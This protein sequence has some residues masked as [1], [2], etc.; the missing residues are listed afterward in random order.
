MSLP[1]PALALASLLALGLVGCG[2][3]GPSRAPAKAPAAAAAPAPEKPR[4]AIA[5]GHLWRDEVDR[6]L[7]TLGLPWL[8]RRV[9]RESAFAKDGRFAGWLITG[10]P[11][12]WSTIDLKP[13]DVVLRVNGKSLETPEDAWDAWKSV[14]GVKEIKLTLERNGAPKELS[15][16]IDGDVNPEIAR[17]M[18]QGPPAGRGQARKPEPERK[19]TVRIGGDPPPSGGGSDWQGE[20]EY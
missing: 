15:I 20:D 12:E 18:E 3:E 13:G 16:P 7:T 5:A 4:P 14:A 1:T 19:G 2:S 17:M 8:F 6:T 11:E 10:L 9:M